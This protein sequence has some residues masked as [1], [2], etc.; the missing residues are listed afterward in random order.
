MTDRPTYTKPPE[1]IRVFIAG[2][3]GSGKSTAAWTLYLSKY[4][5][6]LLLDQTGEWADR[7]DVVVTSV[8]ELS[9]ALKKYAPSG[10]WTISL[11]TDFEALPELVKPWTQT[12]AGAAGLP[13]S[14]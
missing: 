3:S 10:R 11:E 9:W 1:T 7:A 4:P 8:P 14:R 2:V 6:R 13:Q 12:S 5:R